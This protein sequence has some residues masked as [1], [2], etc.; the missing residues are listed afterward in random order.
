[1]TVH[2]TSIDGQI[3]GRF[4]SVTITLWRDLTDAL[5]ITVHSF[6]LSAL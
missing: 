2:A 5:E 3:Q 6:Q 4:L 1:M